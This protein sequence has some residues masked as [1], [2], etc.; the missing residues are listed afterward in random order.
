MSRGR[1]WGREEEFW[2]L[3]GF[4]YNLKF[5]RTLRRNLAMA[6]GMEN[7]K[8]G[9]RILLGV[10]IA[11]I[12][13]SMLLYLVPQGPGTGEAATD[14]VASVGGE[15]VTLS[16]IN[17]QLG[18]LRSRGNV[19]KALES[20]YAHEILKQ[21]VFQKEMDY[22]AK[23]LGIKVSDEERADRIRQ[24]LP[25]AFKDG[26]F[27]GME[28]Y[29]MMVQQNFQMPVET[30]EGLVKD[31]MVE[32]KFRKLITDGISL[33]PAEIKDQFAYDNEKVKLNYVVIKPEE[34][35][36]K[37]VLDEGEIKTYY[38]KNV[39]K[40]QIPEKRVVRY[41]ILDL[42][43]IRQNIQVSDDE[44]KP[45]Y[46]AN[47]AKYQVPN[48][49]QAE[50]ILLMT[51]GKTD[52]EI[53]E[54]RK[55]ADD[56]HAQATKKGAN[57]GE[58]AKKYSEDPGSK[59]NGGKLGWIEQ[60]QTVPEFEKAAFALNPGEVSPVVQS[61]FGFH[62]IKVEAKE[63][64][65]TLPFEE[66][67]VALLPEYKLNKAN[68]QASATADQIAADIRQ[69][70]KV[71][72]DDL[73]KKYK[74]ETGETRA[75]GPND[76]AL[77]L[78]NSK[79]AKQAILALKPGQLSQPIST[80][81]GYVVMTLK[82]V[83]P[84]HQGTLEEVKEKVVADLKLEKSEQVA[85]SKAKDLEDK[86]KGGAKFDVAAKTLGL[87]PK[88]SDLITRAG[89]VPGLGSGKQLSAAFGMKAGQLAPALSLGANW[90]VYQ[91]TEKQ[92]ANPADFDKD[93]AKITDQMLQEKRE[94]AYEAF[95]TSLEERMKKDGKTKLYPERLRGFGDL[96]TP[97][98]LPS[99]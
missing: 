4:D 18:K 62:I 83:L 50:H 20:L 54:L 34:L 78:G 75:L 46:Q 38:E 60:G 48:R 23:R 29:R 51:N 45:I 70:N 26:K 9:V 19:P 76:P 7:K 95:R 98:G 12:A 58:L 71:T 59:G 3:G 69:S 21:L 68:Q 96:N 53:V 39:G 99:E 79:D 84:S 10:V 65:H 5:V 49:V 72:L 33:G 63:Q 81:R 31:S 66:V 56:I 17:E 43:Q 77:E 91:V 67:K 94:L 35:V 61:Q 86:V 92:E 90:A 14:V 25:M 24:I 28:Q 93:K 16:D 64:A 13:A 11:V 2:A 30:F 1:E 89:T 41:A 97:V 37:L 42:N 32:E 8:T 27:V 74:L 55:K 87:D 44:L 52:A 36:A 57:F 22:E 6:G 73:A 82:E 88:V 85:Q 47:I 15:K 40:Y 80:D